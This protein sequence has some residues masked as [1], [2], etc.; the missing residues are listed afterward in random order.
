MRKVSRALWASPWFGVAG[1]LVSVVSV[2]L[3]VVFY[4]ALQKERE[5]VYAAN[6]IR[7]T[8]VAAGQ[9][10]DL[11]ILHG[12]K[13]IAGVDITAAQVAIWNA[14]KQSVRRDNVL[15]D[16]VI[17][18]E[19]SVQILEASIRVRSRDVTGFTLRDTVQ[20]RQEGKV[21][22]SWHILEE[23]D[24]GSV[25]LI[26]AGPQEIN[27]GVRGTIEGLRGIKRVELGVKIKTPTEQIQEQ[28]QNRRF[29]GIMAL[30]YGAL[31]IV[32]VAAALIRR[33][34]RYLFP[35]V[36]ILSMFGICLWLWLSITRIPWPPFGF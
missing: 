15:E 14:G 16:V 5:L 11:E 31:S 36:S 34:W 21:P 1:M 24:G 2:V 30:F 6:P 35:A 33:R 10:S 18:T 19:P 17:F 27:I 22:L 3:A 13:Q 25:Q 29:L 9:S 12:G 32:T 23:N 28:Q 26:Y 8:V 20:S 4:L 7:T